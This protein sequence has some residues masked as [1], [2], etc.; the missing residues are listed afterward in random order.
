MVGRIFNATINFIHSKHDYLLS[1]LKCSTT[2]CRELAQAIAAK[3]PL[4][5]CIGFIDGTLRGICRPKHHQ[6]LVYSGHK[7]KHGLKYQGIMLA[8][9]MMVLHGPWEGRRHDAFLLADSPLLEQLNQLPRANDGQKYILYGDLAYPMR[10][11]I[12]KPYPETCEGPEKTFNDAMK[13][14]RETVEY[15]FNKPVQNFAFVDFHKNQKLYLQP[16]AL[17][18][19]VAVLLSNCHTCLYGSN[20]GS[21]F[22]MSPPSLEEYFSRAS[23]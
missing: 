16:V 14:V 10:E 7:R 20:I 11:Q 13:R 1:E 12:L 6:K 18:Y 4:D 17:Y 21:V 8:N 23:T 5:R 19:R 9:G 15:G 22:K 3:C 2:D